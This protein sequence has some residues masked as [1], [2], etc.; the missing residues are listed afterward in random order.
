MSLCKLSVY[1][2]LATHPDPSEIYCYTIKGSK[3]GFP[4]EQLEFRAEILYKAN[5]LSYSY[6]FT[7]SCHAAL[8]LNPT[9]L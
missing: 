1:T 6:T 7:W 4:E 2:D 9:E 3:S 5:S 8:T